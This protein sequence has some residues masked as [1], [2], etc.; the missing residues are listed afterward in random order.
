MIKVVDVKEEK[1][2][3]ITF[4]VIMRSKAS[5]VICLFDTATTGMILMSGYPQSSYRPGSYQTGL[6]PA[7]EQNMWRKYDGAITIQN[8]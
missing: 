6:V 7:S 8:D 4:P 1:G 2:Q 3:E 5:G